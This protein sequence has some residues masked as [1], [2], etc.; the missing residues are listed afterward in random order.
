MTGLF[1]PDRT[2]AAFNSEGP[3]RVVTS[4][5]YRVAGERLGA[6]LNGALRAG[7]TRTLN[8]R[9]VEALAQR[10]THALRANYE[11]PTAAARALSHHEVHI[12][13]RTWSP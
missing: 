12:V 1:P 9:L 8:Q 10:F 2:T 7:A 4:H 5:R 6:D 13:V 11:T 3:D